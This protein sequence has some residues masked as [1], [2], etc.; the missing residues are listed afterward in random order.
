MPT[1][2]LDELEWQK[3]SNQNAEEWVFDE[4]QNSL[5]FQSCFLKIFSIMLSPD[6]QVI[7]Q[8]YQAQFAGQLLSYGEDAVRQEA[9]KIEK[10]KE[11]SKG[12]WSC[13]IKDVF[14]N[15]SKPI[16]DSIRDAGGVK[17]WSSF[18]ETSL[19]DK[20][21]IKRVKEG[22]FAGD[23][24]NLILLLKRNGHEASVNRAV[25][26]LGNTEPWK[27]V[28]RSEGMRM[29]GNFKSVSHFWTAWGLLNAV[30]NEPPLLDFYDKWKLLLFINLSQV[31]FELG[32]SHYSKAQKTPILMGSEAWVI[33][34]EFPLFA[35]LMSEFLD[36]IEIEP[37]SDEIL[38][39]NEEYKP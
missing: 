37:L 22:V 11:I 34:D 20:N 1:I 27:R 38:K 10:P 5:L 26:I 12:E 3:V 39:A 24:L 36:P 25:Y 30:T 17:T 7:R 19:F 2:D 23:I 13:L 18:R 33:P 9:G 6:D 28:P 32:N 8:Q 31:D 15:I 14:Q 35:D 29:W 16:L 21:F 4:N